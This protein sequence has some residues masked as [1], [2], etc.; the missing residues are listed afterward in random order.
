MLKLKS[1][2]SSAQ[3]YSYDVFLSFSGADTRKTF[4][5]HLYNALINEGLITF[6]D[7][8]EIEKGES[9]KSEL[10]NGIQQSRSWI[11]VF[12]KNYAF[13]SWCLDELVLIL[14]CSNNSKRLLL[15]IFYHVD[16]SDVRK[17]SGCISEAID[18]HEEKFKREVDETKRKNM[19]D[20]IERWRT[21]LTQLAD[22]GGMPLPN[23]ADG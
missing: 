21:A 17:Q 13:S 20:K 4:T 16:P 19:M 3:K 14:E 15:P 2:E 22:L 9:I 11:V 6:R 1:L 8:E 5:D 23:V 7:D 12:S 18:H 10:E